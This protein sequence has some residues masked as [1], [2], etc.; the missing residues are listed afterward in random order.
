MANLLFASRESDS[1]QSEKPGMSQPSRGLVL[2]DLLYW[3]S[4]RRDRRNQA[5]PLLPL[6]IKP[7]G[8]PPYQIARLEKANFSRRPIDMFDELPGK[9]WASPRGVEGSVKNPSTPGGR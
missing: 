7:A 5:D 1:L 2:Q 8:R 6:A 4:A 9:L 3:R